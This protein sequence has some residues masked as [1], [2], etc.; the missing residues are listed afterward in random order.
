[1]RSSPRSRSS[2]GPQPAGIRTA[3]HVG[4]FNGRTPAAPGAFDNVP[5]A[6]AAGIMG[7]C[8]PHQRLMS[9]PW[10]VSWPAGEWSCSAA[11]LSTE[12]GI[13]DYRGPSAAATRRQAPMTHQAF[14]GDPVARRRTGAR[15]HVGWGLMAQAVPNA[16]CRGDPARADGSCPGDDPRR[17]WMACTPPPALAAWSTCTAASTGWCAWAALPRPPAHASPSDSQQPT[18]PGS[19]APPP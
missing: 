1:M 18:S 7:G 13:P 16:A 2:E 11:R 3:I 6:W 17:T 12:S 14:V 15:S 9:P 19:G 8:S 4:C 10:R 5:L